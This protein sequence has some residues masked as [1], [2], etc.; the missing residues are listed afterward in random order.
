M[1][2]CGEVYYMYGPFALSK[3]CDEIN[4]NSAHVLL[5]WVHNAIVNYLYHIRLPSL[6]RYG[7]D[8][9][10]NSHRGSVLPFSRINPSIRQRRRRKAIDASS[11]TLK[12]PFALRLREIPVTPTSRMPPFVLNNLSYHAFIFF[13]FL[14]IIVFILVISFYKSSLPPGFQCTG[15]PFR[16]CG[17]SRGSKK[18]LKTFHLSEMLSELRYFKICS[19][20]YSISGCSFL[21]SHK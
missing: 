7:Q 21:L 16:W 8:Q 1:L 5:D 20:R 2:H 12:V 9:T 10:V 13:L 19:V 11:W 3:A 14:L 6:F 18:L 4:C 15:S 17:W